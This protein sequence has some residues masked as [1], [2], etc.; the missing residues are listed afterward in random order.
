MEQLSTPIG[1]SLA[2]LAA[3]LL[4]LS[5]EST[6][7]D[8]REEQQRLV[9]AERLSRARAQRARRARLARRQKRQA[10]GPSTPA[11]SPPRV[12]P[13]TPCT[14]AA[15]LR[16]Q[17]KS[18]AFNDR[19]AQA[20]RRVLQPIHADL[21]DLKGKPF[22]RFTFTVRMHPKDAPRFGRRGGPA[23]LE[24]DLRWKPMCGRT[25]P[26]P[27][28][29]LRVRLVR[30]KGKKR[31]PA[32]STGLWPHRSNARSFVAPVGTPLQL[33]LDPARA[34][35]RRVRRATGLAPLL[36]M[37]EIEAARF[38][39]HKR[40]QRLSLP[41]SALPDTLR[42]L[43]AV[44]VE[45]NRN[46][47]KRCRFLTRRKGRRSIVT[48]WKALVKLAAPI[49]SAKAVR[50]L[51]AAMLS[52]HFGPCVGDVRRASKRRNLHTCFRRRAKLPSCQFWR[53]LNGFGNEALV[54]PQGNR[55]HVQH[56]IAC[57]GKKKRVLQLLATYERKGRHTQT[58]TDLT[59]RTARLL[60]GLRRLT[61]PR[62]R[63]R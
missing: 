36:G 42:Q 38:V 60:Q 6:R 59:P 55:F 54:S 13:D 16:Q 45:C 18:G 12:T 23:V 51:H 11:T 39:G 62:R 30:P 29:Q 50:Q 25:R 21:V 34:T 58:V 5:C 15:A 44:E 24:L 9:R 28:Q 19:F 56:V 14:P 3:M 53:A 47:H 48:T 63:R 1:S 46:K 37:W 22:Q 41:T 35:L 2:A 31:V 26:G 52:L 43:H 20:V 61:S 27:V 8:D 49:G 40:T 10:P 33:I 57:P 32:V 17:A 7:G 4:L